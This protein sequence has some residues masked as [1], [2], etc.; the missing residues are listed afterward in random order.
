MENPWQSWLF[1]H[2]AILDWINSCGAKPTTT[3]LGLFGMKLEKK[4]VLYSTSPWIHALYRQLPAKRGAEVV[5][6]S[7]LAEN[8]DSG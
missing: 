2:P 4:L 7:I 1:K 6:G 8:L 3:Q 5:Q